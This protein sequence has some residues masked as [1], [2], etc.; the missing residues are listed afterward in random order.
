MSSDPRNDDAPYKDTTDALAHWME[1]P[2]CIAARLDDADHVTILAPHGVEDLLALRARP[3]AA[4]Q[5]KM[6][7]YRARMAA[8]NWAG[9]W[10]GL[11]VEYL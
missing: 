9:L 2:T 7:Q 6:D 3:T 4:A 11:S 8:K 10:P 1:T 5:S